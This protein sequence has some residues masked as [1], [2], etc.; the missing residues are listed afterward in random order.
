MGKIYYIPAVI[1]DVKEHT[2][3]NGY[4]QTGVTFEEANREEQKKPTGSQG[5]IVE[6]YVERDSVYGN[7]SKG[8]GSF[9]RKGGL[10]IYRNEMMK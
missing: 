5:N 1:T 3:A 9:D 10:I 8:L 7:K 6:W 4:F 2:G